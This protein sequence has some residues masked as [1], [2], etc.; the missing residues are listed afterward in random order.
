LASAAVFLSAFFLLDSLEGFVA[1][2]AANFIF[3]TAAL[4]LAHDFLGQGVILM[5]T[6]VVDLFFY[7]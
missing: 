1:L 5:F 2:V 3:F 4:A 7:F 6:I